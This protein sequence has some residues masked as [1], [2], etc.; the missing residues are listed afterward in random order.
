MD[1]DLV[2]INSDMCACDTLYR[3]KYLNIYCTGLLWRYG[4]EA[5][6]LGAMQPHFERSKKT[7]MGPSFFKREDFH[8]RS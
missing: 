5:E 2:M 7:V 3:Y 4:D 6:A 8:Y 1:V